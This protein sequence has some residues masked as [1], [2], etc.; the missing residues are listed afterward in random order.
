M[1]EC[2]G[3][4]GVD[5]IYGRRSRTPAYS[6]GVQVSVNL[7]GTPRILELCRRMARDFFAEH[8]IFSHPKPAPQGFR[9]GSFASIQGVMP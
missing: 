5:P 4:Q 6:K 7:I 9:N 2:M 3:S 8:V 1:F